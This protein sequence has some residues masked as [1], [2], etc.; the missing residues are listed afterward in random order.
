M[1]TDEYSVLYG[2]FRVALV[3]LGWAACALLWRRP[4]ARGGLALL[5]GLNLVTWA[6]CVWP[7]QRLYGLQ[8]HNDRGFNV[9]MASVAAAGNSPFE[10]TQAGF[11]GLEPFWSALVAAL[12]L[13][14]PE[15]VVPVYGWLAPLSLLGVGCGLYLGLRG[16]G[17]EPDRWERTL[18][19]LAVL[20]LASFSLSQR[21][22]IPA[23]WAGN[24]LY[25][26]NHILAFALVPVAIG[27]AFPRVRTLRL[28]LVLGLL[29]WAFLVHWAF[30]LPGLWIGA[31][32]RPPA[33]REWRRLAAATGLSLVLAAPYL[34]HLGRDYNPL[35]KAGSPEQLW[36]EP[37]GQRLAPPYW[38]TLDLGPL[39]VLG[40][41]GGA[42]LWR[43]RS[44]RD[45]ALLGLLAAS[46]LFW[47]GYELGALV[48][49]TPEPD[50]QH[51]FLR[52]AMALAAGAA[53]A[54]LARHVEGAAGLLAGRGAVLVLAAA[55]PLSFVAYWDPPTMDRYFRWDRIPIGPKVRAYGEWVRAHTPPDAIFAAGPNACMWIPVFSGR[56]VLLA[57]GSRPP[58]DYFARK[59][60]ERIFVL[61]RRPEL[62]RATARRFGVD[63]LAVDGGMLLE[64]GEDSFDGL[65][66]LPVYELQYQTS[67]VRIFRIVP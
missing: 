38:A 26:P 64:Y 23:L 30:L 34:A 41:L 9:G 33:E 15:N 3:A 43:R 50:E 48:G 16:T 12:A 27:L 45:A 8:E 37:L 42:V 32:L 63:Y 10:H 19:V 40:A 46:W 51:Y 25:K 47:L 66:R 18:S 67:A 31:W 57:G 4:R 13:F 60:A 59:E 65:G 5:L 52:L 7:L 6:A 49:V 28:G 35:D 36:L 21:P 20:G 22:P 11:A 39:L 14:R 62:I 2:W 1:S 24:F 54:A 53:L 61:S 29:A 44:P 58:R 17:D 55:L 56:R